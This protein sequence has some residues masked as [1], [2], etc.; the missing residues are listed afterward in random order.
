MEMTIDHHRLD[1]HCSK[2]KF[3]DN[4]KGEGDGKRDFVFVH[5]ERM[6][7]LYPWRQALLAKLFEDQGGEASTL[8]Q[9][10]EEKGEP[11]FVRSDDTV[12]AAGRAIARGRKAVSE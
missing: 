1:V 5:M 11:Q 7:P 3:R 9:L 6:F 8:G 2:R 10:L 4:R 12:R